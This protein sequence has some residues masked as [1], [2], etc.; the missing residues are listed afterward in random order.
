MLIYSSN[1]YTCFLCSTEPRKWW[2]KRCPWKTQRKATDVTD[3]LQSSKRAIKTVGR[4]QWHV[5]YIAHKGISLNIK[6]NGVASYRCFNS[7]CLILKK[8]FRSQ[9]FSENFYIENIINENRN[10]FIITMHF[11]I[12]CRNHEHRWWIIV[13][14]FNMYR[15]T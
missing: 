15:I 13:Y 14:T 9:I 5:S 6:W 8:S 10:M 3:Q 1:L 2:A 11:P 4:R 12:I 7:F